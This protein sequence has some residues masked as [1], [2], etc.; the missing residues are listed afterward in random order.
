MIVAFR[1]ENYACKAEPLPAFGHRTNIHLPALQ[2]ACNAP[3]PPAFA[4]PT[5]RSPGEEDGAQ[6]LQ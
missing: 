5:T 2:Q 3:H 6:A 4:G 1:K